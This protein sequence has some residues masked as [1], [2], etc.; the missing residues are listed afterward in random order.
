VGEREG[1]GGEIGRAAMWLYLICL[2]ILK[3]RGFY[4]I[5]E[6]IFIIDTARI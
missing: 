2:T 4:Y 5:S 1:G 3:T 6:K